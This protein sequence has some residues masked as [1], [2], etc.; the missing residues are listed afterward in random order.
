MDKNGYVSDP[1]STLGISVT[2]EQTEKTTV[3]GLQ[4]KP[5]IGCQ[6]NH[7]NVL[8]SKTNVAWLSI[9]ANTHTWMCFIQSQQQKKQIVFT[10]YGACYVK[11][12]CLDMYI[13]RYSCLPYLRGITCDTHL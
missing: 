5:N 9:D 3:I 2:I 13:L 10:V 11:V 6:L 4:P 8:H 12:A 7:C 1:L